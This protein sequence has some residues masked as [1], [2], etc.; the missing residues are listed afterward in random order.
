MD[1]GKKILPDDPDLLKE[2]IINL[3]NDYS[4]LN[5][6]YTELDDKYEDL[7]EK[8]QYLR[9][10]LYG[11]K[12][13][14]LSKEDELQMRLFNEAEDGLEENTD[15]HEEEEE[16]KNDK[17]SVKGY[18][19]QKRGRKPIPDHYPRNEIIHDLP[20]NEKKCSCCSKELPCIGEEITEEFE[21]RPQEVTV[22]KHIKKKYGPCDCEESFQKEI[23]EIKTAS[24]PPRF[25]PKGIASSSLVAYIIT[26]KFCDALPFYRQSNIF[27][28]M[29]IDIS[30]ATL[31]NWAILA[32]RNC[33]PLIDI[34][35]EEIQR[36]PVIRMDETTLQVLQEPD[37]PATSLSR[38]WV[39]MGYT[40]D[41]K[42]LILYKYY[43]TR[44]GDVP[45][46]IL[47]NFKGILQTDGY[48]GYNKVVIKNKLIHVGCFAHSRREFEKALKKAKKSK[49]PYNGLQYIRS[50]YKI[51][52]DLR[53]LN[54]PPQEFLEK[55]KEA[56]LPILEKFHNWLCIQK[57]GM[58]PSGY[59]GKAIT[60]TLNQWDKL[61]RY[62]D[63]Y[64]L[65]PDNNLV[66]NAIRPYAV[67]RK[68]WLFSNTPRGA[69]S[70][71]ALYTLVESAKANNLDPYKYLKYI[72]DRIPGAETREDFRALLPD[73]LTVEMIKNE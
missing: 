49:L 25:I 1:S 5:N 36:G 23:P 17:T 50:I 20:E 13:E 35:T 30:R 12:S 60:Y 47:G 42:S 71:A 14:K 72:F 22:N 31:C 64:L 67:G 21:I 52:S 51:E 34:I 44:S 45:V 11:R 54:L 9:R 56:A 8:Y 26:S 43:P 15:N 38:M 2:M 29:D 57:E 65:T 46:E 28:R 61:I 3:Q 68:N 63:H 70:S 7:E 59:T 53:S 41:E 48:D 6:K 19:R 18:T 37:K 55:R 16:T 4:S 27:N 10:L 66:E 58:L 32:A 39:T 69:H 24:M 33:M 40:S 73:R 62:L